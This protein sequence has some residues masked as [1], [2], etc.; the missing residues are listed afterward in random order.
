MTPIVIASR[1]VRQSSQRCPATRLA[2]WL[3]LLGMLLCAA[4]AHAQSGDAARTNAKA[5]F[6]RGVADYGAGQYASALS[7]FQ[8]AFRVRPHPLVNVNIA[9]CYDKL[10]K[11]L[12]AI[13]HFQR[14]LESDAGTPAQRDEVKAAVERLKQQIGKVNLRITPDG[15]LAILDAGEQRKAP[16]LDPVQL[17]AGKHTLEVRAE[18]YKTVQRNLSVKGGATLEITVALEPDKAPVPVAAAVAEPTLTVTPSATPEPARRPSRSSPSRHRSR[19][20]PLN[21]P[22]PRARKCRLPPSR[23]RRRRPRPRACRHGSGSPAA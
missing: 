13:F 15:A 5:L 6:E 19:P 2:V 20:Q 10:G 14:F 7:S 12:Q 4:T 11:P 3:Q 23:S 9:N 17:E 8:E 21:G 1:A 16:I 18:G 22:R